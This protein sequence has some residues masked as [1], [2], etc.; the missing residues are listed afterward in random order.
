[1]Q[2]LNR[3]LNKTQK[4][5]VLAILTLNK[6][7]KV[8]QKIIKVNQKNNNSRYYEVKWDVIVGIYPKNTLKILKMDDY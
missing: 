7:M 8:N 5:V 6:K 3:I 1:M 2:T 4:L